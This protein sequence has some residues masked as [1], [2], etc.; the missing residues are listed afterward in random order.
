MATI[1]G[2]LRQLFLQLTE[3]PT[4][5][6]DAEILL[7]YALN[8]PR[9]YLYAHADDIIEEEKAAIFNELLARR[10]KGEPI[11]YITEHQEFWSLDLCV[12]RDVLIPRPETEIL[13]E[14]ALKLFPE[15]K[16]RFVLDLGTGSGAISLAIAKERPLW[17][18]VGVDRSEKA[19]AIA[20]KNQQ[21]LHISNATFMVSDWF[22]AVSEEKP[23]DLIVSNPPYISKSDPHLSQGDVRFEP[24]EALIS[25][26]DGLADIQ[27]ISVNAMR[28][29]K[30]GG[31]LVFEHGYD[32]AEPVR[33]I[34]LRD[35]Y[36]LVRSIK[37]LSG[38]ERVTIGKKSDC[39]YHNVL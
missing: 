20:K 32:Q 36:I 2:A 7:S 37:D 12:S 15:N 30:S 35:Q 5:K 1:G 25:G 14:T 22:S 39:D 18:V 13:V 28:Y 9:S 21:R 38:H 3:S 11:A 24:K 16:K 31:Y 33:A 19:M 34:L 4:P 10:K 29:L 6:F 23:F 17:D 8:A 26:E 27:S